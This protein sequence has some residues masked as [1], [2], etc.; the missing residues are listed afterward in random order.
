MCERILETLPQRLSNFRR[1]YAGKSADDWKIFCSCSCSCSPSRFQEEH[2]EDHHRVLERGTMHSFP[3]KCLNL[4]SSGLTATAVSPNI[5][6]GRV[7]ATCKHSVLSARGYLNVYNFPASSLYSTWGANMRRVCNCTSYNL[8]MAQH[9]ALEDGY[10]E[11]SK[12]MKFIP[13]V[14]EQQHSYPY[15]FSWSAQRTEP[16]TFPPRALSHPSRIP[17][18]SNPIY[19]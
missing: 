16:Q 12:G 1:D 8:N 5:V 10:G 17:H 6:S 15:K 18:K 13:H 2:G 7:V 11:R 4:S 3:I 14:S 9:A 19:K